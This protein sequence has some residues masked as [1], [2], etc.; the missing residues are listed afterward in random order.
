MRISTER[1]RQEHRTSA[2]VPREGAAQRDPRLF[3]ALDLVG[4]SFFGLCSC[5]LLIACS[6]IG[7]WPASMGPE[8]LAGCALMAMSLHVLLASRRVSTVDPVIWIPV[9]FLVFYF[10]MPFARFLGA[11][12]AYDAWSVPAPR[13]LSRGFGVAL[14]TLT[15]FIAG[16]YLHGIDD[17]RNPNRTAWPTAAFLGWAGLIVFAIGALSMLVGFIRAG[18]SLILGM[19]G[20]IY[21]SKAVGVD[22]RLFD[23]GLILT[24]AGVI[25]LLAAHRPRRIVWHA[26]LLSKI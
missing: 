25:G 12:I 19:Y 9:A 11:H 22:F 24:K 8:F 6:T 17:R 1:S 4:F 2:S 23:V 7:R 15:A 13:N 26:T 10:G 14:L 18:P 21:E 3:R 16:M 20:E 5:I